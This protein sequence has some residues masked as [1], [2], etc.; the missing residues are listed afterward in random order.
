MKLI[1]LF[2]LFVSGNVIAQSFILTTKSSF[3]NLGNSSSVTFDSDN[4]GDNDLLVLGKSGEFYYTKIYRNNGDSTFLDLGIAIPGLAHGGAD[5]LDFNN[6]GA[7]DLV[8]CGN[9]GSSRQFYLYQNIGNN[10]FVEVPTSIPGVDYASV[11]CSDLNLDGYCDII[12]I[13]QTST[14]KIAQIHKNNGDNTFSLI[15]SLEGVYDGDIITQDINND[16]WPD[17]ILSGV[18]NSFQLINKIYLNQKNPDFEFQERVSN[19]AAIRGGEIKISD[20][21]NDSYKDIVITGKDIND[22]YITRTY[23]NNFGLSFTLSDNLTGLYYSSIATGDFNNNGYPDIFV[24]GLDINSNYKTIFYV[25]NTGSGFSEQSTNLPDIVKGSFS[26]VNLTQDNKLDIFVSGYTMAGPVSQL[27]YNSITIANSVPAVPSGLFSMANHD[28]VLIGW[29]YSADSET[30]SKG[31]T[32]SYFILNKITGDTIFP[33]PA[34]FTNGNRFLNKQGTVNDTSIILS[35]LPYGQYSWSVQSVDQGYLGSPYAT[36]EE[37]IICHNFD[38]GNDTSLCMGDTIFLAA[39]MTNDVVD[40][41]SSDSPTIPLGSGNSFQM[42]VFNPVSIW[43]VVTSP[44]GCVITDTIEISIFQLPE[45][46]L[47]DTIS[48]QNSVLT[49]TLGREDFLGNWTSVSGYVNETGKNSISVKMTQEEQI[50]IE[51]T[52]SNLCVNFDTILLEIIEPPTSNLP[53]DTSQCIKST[54]NLQAGSEY[55][56]VIWFNSSDEVVSNSGFFSLEIKS[57]EKYKMHIIDTN[58]CT[59]KD[60]IFIKALSLPTINAGA[61]TLICPATSILVGAIEEEAGTEYSWFPGK[62]LSDSTIAQPVASPLE[63][64]EYVLLVSDSNKCSNQDTI[65]I[66][67]NSPTTIDAGGNRFVCKGQSVTLGGNPT[68]AG[69]LMPYEYNWIPNISLDNNKLPNPTIEE[70]DSTLTYF[71]IVETGSCIVDTV[72]VGVEVFD[73]PVVSTIDDVNIGFE[74]SIEIW[75]SGGTFYNWYPE[76]GLNNSEISNPTASPETSTLY[77][78]QV[79]DSN[80]CT[81]S[82]EVKVTIKNKIFIPNLFTPNNDGKNDFFLVYGNGIGSIDLKVY[83]PDGVMVYETTDV[84]EATKIGWDGTFKGKPINPGKYL[85]VIEAVSTSSE[86][87]DFEG[88]NKGI[89]TLLR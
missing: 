75:A 15:N 76:E 41:Y 77:S 70:C 79:T 7:I 89:I 84:D 28:S 43:A 52:D 38:L 27:F 78:V 17:I 33:S 81:N 34:S 31:L 49:F 21:N 72:P 37:F 48:C 71:L 62:Y 18:N 60:S 54:I 24:S 64:I 53:E 1:Y 61:D 2:F 51:I 35:G 39:G 74:E 58:G 40:W 46:N 87:L 65:L 20:F 55:D 23:I 10:Q 6:D 83:S 67:I 44:L 3:E 88:N 5:V 56:S 63:S 14:G 30:G 69:S 86:L 50:F 29:N 68:A 85:W 12:L 19:I 4:D 22:N 8:V 16:D 13:G 47:K 57:T 73:L 36:T 26:P 42:A 9:D 59:A 66:T 11:K 45:K 25:N 32:Y 80:G 82:S